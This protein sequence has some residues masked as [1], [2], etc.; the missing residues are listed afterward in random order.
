VY[1]S[2]RRYLTSSL[3]MKNELSGALLVSKQRRTSRN[4]YDYANRC[5]ID[6]S[7]HLHGEL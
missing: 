2:D 4:I 5:N 3:L 1:I 6:F 7:L